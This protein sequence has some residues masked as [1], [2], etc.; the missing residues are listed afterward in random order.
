MMHYIF[1]ANWGETDNF[2]ILNGDP[3]KVSELGTAPKQ[4]IV[5]VMT[6]PTDIQQLAFVE[7]STRMGTVGVSVFTFTRLLLPTSIQNI[8]LIILG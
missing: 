8:N 2:K 5:N 6:K 4:V 3:V 7:R 1:R